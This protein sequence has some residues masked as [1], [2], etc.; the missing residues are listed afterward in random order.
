MGQIQPTDSFVN[1]VL[2]EATAL[3]HTDIVYGGFC[4]TWFCVDRLRQ[5]RCVVHRAPGSSDLDLS[6]ESALVSASHHDVGMTQQQ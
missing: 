1:K 6:G 4:A 3:V 2:L 5:T